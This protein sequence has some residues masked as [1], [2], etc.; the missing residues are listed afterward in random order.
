MIFTYS[1]KCHY[2]QG[3]IEQFVKSIGPC[4]P[5]S[6]AKMTQA[7]ETGSKVSWCVKLADLPVTTHHRTSELLT[8]CVFFIIKGDISTYNTF[9]NKVYIYQTKNGEPQWSAINCIVSTCLFKKNIL[10][11]GKLKMLFFAFTYFEK[12]AT[13]KF[14][15]RKHS[16]T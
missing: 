5:Y 2:E 15:Q 6:S 16:N 7:C 11:S 8:P 10:V 4:F 13:Y 9:R 14:C 12:L 3:C 1:F